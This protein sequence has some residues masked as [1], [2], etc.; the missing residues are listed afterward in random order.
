V[1]MET[2]STVDV[3]GLQVFNSSIIACIYL[4]DTKFFGVCTTYLRHWI[5]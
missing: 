2:C 3:D 4:K 1:Q 5:K